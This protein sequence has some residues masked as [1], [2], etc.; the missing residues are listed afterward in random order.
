M[1]VYLIIL[2][3]Y[4]LVAGVLIYFFNRD[5]QNPAVFLGQHRS[6]AWILMGVLVFG[7]ICGVDARFI[8]INRLVVHEETVAT[9][10]ITKPIRIAFIGD[11]HVGGNK[12]TAWT[13]KVVNKI[14][15]QKPDLVIIGGDSVYNHGGNL[16]ESEYLE[17]LRELPKHFPTYYVMGNH[18][19]GY[20]DLGF[21]ENADQ[22]AAVMQKMNDM[23]LVLLKNQLGCPKVG[24]ERVCL[25]GI[26][27][28]YRN[29]VSFDEV[30]KW[31]KT[32][33]LI[34]VTHNPDG[35]LAWPDAT[36]VPAL[37]L[38]AHTHGGQI[39][40]PFIGPLGRVPVRLGT[41]YYRGLNDYNGLKIFTTVGVSESGG[42]IR[43]LTPPEI[44]IIT[45]AP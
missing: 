21:Q 23:G 9:P 28:V 22:S 16:D 18:E 17:P 14:I 27:D 10:D 11:L 20:A 43:F 24:S 42:P 37:T 6:L 35:I 5:R 4:F 25:Y 36:S 41:K 8:E 45:L 7:I 34:L 31:N 3:G 1:N 19:Y 40:L 30:T 29:Q 38:A 44:A 26:D 2:Y 12:K 33:P 13:Q 32:A 39:W 15:E